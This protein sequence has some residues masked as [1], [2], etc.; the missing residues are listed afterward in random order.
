MGKGPDTKKIA[1]G[2]RERRLAL[3]AAVIIACWGFLGWVV[4]PMLN[5][6]YELQRYAETHTEKLQALRRL[7]RQAALTEQRYQAYAGY[8]ESVDDEHAQGLFLDELE[9]LSTKSNVQIN[10]KPRPGRR[11]E[12]VSRFEVE[13]DVEGSQQHVMAF[14]DEL[15]HLLKLIEIER[16]R[17]TAVPMKSDVLRA[18]LLLQKL[19]V[20]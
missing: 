5:R 12:R 16:I 13:L 18:N 15:F 4:Q 20:R 19:T 6:S 1:I 10:F 9:A 7:E 14:L 17:I 11:E 2:P 8:L 3:V